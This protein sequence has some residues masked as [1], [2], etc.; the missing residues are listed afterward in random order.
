MIKNYRKAVW[1]LAAMLMVPSVSAYAANMDETKFPDPV[2][3]EYVEAEVDTDKNGVLSESEIM[4]VERIVLEDSSLKSLQGIE[5]FSHLKELDVSG[6]DLSNIYL[7]SNI[8]LEKLDCSNNKLAY[9]NVDSNI[10]LKELD[11]GGAEQEYTFLNLR[12]NSRLQNLICKNHAGLSSVNI[13]NSTLLETLDLSGSGITILDLSGN[14]VMETLDLKGVRELVDLNLSRT[15]LK[16]VDLSYNF[17]LT[18]LDLSYSNIETLNMNNNTN[19]ISLNLQGNQS[20]KCL[21]LHYHTYLDTL[22]IQDTCIETLILCNTALDRVDLSTITTLKSVKLDYNSRL[23]DINL[24]TE[25]EMGYLNLPDNASGE[26]EYI[27]KIKLEGNTLDSAE[28]TFFDA[29]RVK[30]LHNV[31]FQDGIFTV[32]ILGE[33][34]YYVY[35]CK[36]TAENPVLKVKL[37]TEKPKEETGEGNTQGEGNEGTETG[38]GNTQGEGNEGT[39]TGGNTQGE[40]NEGTETGGGSTQGEGSEGTE[41]GGSTQ[42]EGNEGTE[43]EGGNTQGEGNEGTETEGGNTQGEGNE[44]TETGGGNTQGEG[45]E[46]TETGGEATQGEGSEGT[47]TGGEA[48]QGKGSERTEAEDENS[49]EKGNKN[50]DDINIE[51][52]KNSE[53]TGQTGNGTNSQNQTQESDKA[54]NQEKSGEQKNGKTGERPWIFTDVLVKPGHWKY[55]SVRKVYNHEIMGAVGNSSEFQPGKRLTRAMFATILYRMA[56]E[57]KV[58]YTLKFL[59]VAADKWYSNAIVWA[60]AKEIVEGYS[61]GRYGINDDITREQIAKMLYYFAKSQGYHVDSRAELNFT[62]TERVSNWANIPIQWSV[63]SGM[64]NGKPN[65]DGSFRLDPKGKALRSEC[66]KMIKMFME[67]VAK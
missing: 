48:A 57:P 34:A 59:D 6:N 42:G 3:R 51:E 31:K 9:L 10:N 29:G 61:D 52:N 23:T 54:G 37:L 44:G 21:D 36:E 65:E 18:N 45:N 28:F 66:A 46:G 63:A 16:S 62:D 32:T 30:Q 27:S 19:L 38:G 53:K 24:N 8:R 12:N 64:I 60:S 47:E 15:K 5:L 58:E 2:F 4:A 26:A 7:G 14:Q 50:K 55:E 22:N 1:V 40:G 13:K 25:A 20:L 67:N 41:T 35:Q 39:E 43:T 56:G 49:K 33:E 17:S 11:C